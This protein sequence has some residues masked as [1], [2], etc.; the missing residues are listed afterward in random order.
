MHAGEAKRTWVTRQPEEA[1]NVDCLQPKFAR[2]DHSMIWGSICHG[3]KSELVFWDKKDC[4]NISFTTYQQH[5]LLSLRDFYAL[6]RDTSPELPDDVLVMQDNA[7]P[8]KAKTTIASLNDEHIPLMDW[9]ASS[10][11]LNP[12]ENV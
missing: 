7:P 11:D 1:Y 3:S 10:P 9:P 12:I 6:M 4:G 8:H 5:I 2:L